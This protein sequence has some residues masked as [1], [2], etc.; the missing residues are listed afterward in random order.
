MKSKR[1]GIKGGQRVIIGFK[2]QNDANIL[3]FYS[4]QFSIQ[5]G[6][7]ESASE[8]NKVSCDADLIAKVI[9]NFL[10][11]LKRSFS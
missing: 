5:E 10:P 8:N 9:P 3:Y 4:L 11:L 6:S 2:Q 1:L 7:K